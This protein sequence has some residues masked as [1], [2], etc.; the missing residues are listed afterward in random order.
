M[1]V[2]MEHHSR[3]IIQHEDYFVV[4]ITDKELVQLNWTPK[5]GDE[6][7]VA[8]VVEFSAFAGSPITTTD[9][10]KLYIRRVTPAPAGAWFLRIEGVSV[11]AAIELVNKDEEG[12]I[13]IYKYYASFA[14]EAK[15]K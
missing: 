11:D 3:N 6:I 2:I 9:I 10:C 5:E 4:S 7:V 14:V 15:V 8:P 13:Q 1:G 12:L